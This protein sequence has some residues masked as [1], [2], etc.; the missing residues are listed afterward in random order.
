MAIKYPVDK[1]MKYCRRPYLIIGYLAGKFPNLFKFVPD[2]ICIKMQFKAAT[3]QKLNLKNP[4]TFNEKIQWLKLHGDLQKYAN[5]ADKYEVRKFVSNSIGEEYLIPLLG[6]WDKFKDI[7]FGKLPKQFVLKCNHD[8]NSVVICKDK[9]AFNINKAREKLNK[10]LKRKFYYAFRE[11]QYKNIKPKIICEKYMVDE[12]G[13]ELKDY[14][15]FCFN[16]N[17]KIIQVNYDRF[18]SSK[19]NLYDIEWNYIPVAMTYPTDP[20]RI[21]NKPSKLEDMLV[22]AKTLSKGIPCVR[23]DF[24]SINDKIYFGELTFTPAAGLGKF[25]PKEFDFEMGSWIELPKEKK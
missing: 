16:G 19:K 21:I 17:P 24:Y 20:N 6:V 15:I 22:F 13:S 4:Q 1:I 25:E 7:D 5:L 18:T 9:T 23:V 2:K 8:S 11:Y 3:G 14:K 12:S 10:C